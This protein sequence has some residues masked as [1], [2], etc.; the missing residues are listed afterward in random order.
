MLE[1]D[2]IVDIG[3]GAGVNGGRVVAQGSIEDI[4]ACRDSLTGQYLSG[5]K[6]IPV[7]RQRRKAVAGS[8]RLPALRKT[9]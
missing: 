9:S 8:L 6:E 5:F 4:M 7:P 2:Y 3:P 1:A